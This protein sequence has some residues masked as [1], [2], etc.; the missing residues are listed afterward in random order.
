MNYEREAFERMIQRTFGRL[1]PTLAYKL[2]ERS[3]D[4]Y[5]HLYVNHQWVGWKAAIE[6]ERTPYV[7]SN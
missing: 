3:E 5:L 6:Y 1:I 7:G 4:G 2:F